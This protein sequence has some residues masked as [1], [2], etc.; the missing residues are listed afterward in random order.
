MTGTAGGTGA[1]NKC[2][3]CGHEW[4]LSQEIPSPLVPNPRQDDLE[5]EECPKCGSRDFESLLYIW[6]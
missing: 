5:P 4:E 1:E 6:N 3:S 2:N